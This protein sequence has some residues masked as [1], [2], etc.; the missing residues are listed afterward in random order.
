M[1]KIHE[2]IAYMILV[3]IEMLQKMLPEVARR[4]TWPL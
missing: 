1:A 2:R 4:L 3:F